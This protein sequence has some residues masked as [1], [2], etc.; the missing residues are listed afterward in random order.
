MQM[1]TVC[2]L[3]NSNNSW[4]SGE[5]LAGLMCG[6]NVSDL[7][8]RGHCH[9]PTSLLDVTAGDPNESSACLMCL[10]LVSVQHGFSLIHSVTTTTTTTRFLLS[11]AIVQRK[12]RLNT[13][14]SIH[15]RMDI[16]W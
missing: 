9:H 6:K 13:E 4:G 11:T 14:G 8:H 16:H 15:T 2:A 3:N 1:G 7:Q 10:S 5:R 12:I